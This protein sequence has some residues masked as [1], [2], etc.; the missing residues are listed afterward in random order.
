[1]VFV[2]AVLMAVKGRMGWRTVVLVVVMVGEFPHPET[3]SDS[4]SS[5][6]RS[7]NTGNKTPSAPVWK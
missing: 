3:S 7:S 1:M 6:V 4:V 5:L 2:S